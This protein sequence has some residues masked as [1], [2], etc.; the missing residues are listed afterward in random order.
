[1][2][3]NGKGLKSSV[4]FFDALEDLERK[5]RALIDNE[6]PMGIMSGLNGMDNILGGFKPTELSVIAARTGVGKT[7]FMIN[8]AREA[9]LKGKKVAFFTLEMPF[10]QI[11]SRLMINLVEIPGKLLTHSGYSFTVAER[12]L[13]KQ[14]VSY[15]VDQL[16]RLKEADKLGKFWINDTRRITVEEVLKDCQSMDG[17]D[18]VFVD[19]IQLVSPPQDEKSKDRHLQLGEITM[20]LHDMAGDLNVPVIAGAQ[21]R[22]L[23]GQKA[24]LEDLRESGS[25]EQ[26]SDQVILLERELD[27]DG[28]LPKEGPGTITVLKNRH[29]LSG[30]APFYYTGSYFKFEDHEI[31][32]GDQ[33]QIKS[34]P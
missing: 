30:S 33:P 12:D 7:A 31:D 27:E 1:M 15:L 4:D 16:R 13:F 11:A 5:F 6:H 24:G 17:L 29:G 14:K 34:K 9:Y 18:M 22:R 8:L 26:D 21:L 3:E 23:K 28:Q 2:S 10:M 19:Y 20:Q 25:L 32:D